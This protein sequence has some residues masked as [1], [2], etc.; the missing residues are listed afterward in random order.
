M[1]IWIWIA[2]L[3]IET[4][5]TIGKFIELPFFSFSAGRCGAFETNCEGSKTLSQLF[6]LS[7]LKINTGAHAKHELMFNLHL[8]PYNS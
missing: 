7:I 6:I 4:E 1:Q 2:G 8:W 5:I 3:G